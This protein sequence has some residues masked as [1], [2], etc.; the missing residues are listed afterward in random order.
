[1]T[2]RRNVL[3]SFLTAA[4]LAYSVPLSAQADDQAMEI[5]ITLT[6]MK[7]M[8]EAIGGKHVDVSVLVPPGTHPRSFE[9]TPMQ[10]AAL[11][12]S[13]LYI[14][15]GIPH[16]QNWLPQI[17]A[18]R[19]DMPML[20]FIESV[21]TRQRDDRDIEDPHI[22]LGPQQLRDMAE[23][24]RDTLS[25]LA[26]NHADEFAVNADAW[27]ARLDA[28]DADAKVRLAPYEGRAFLVFH[29]AFGYFADSYGLRQIAIEQRG[30]EPGPQRI[31]SAIDRARAENIGTVFMQV[32][33]AE[34]EAKTIAS[35]IGAKVVTSNPLAPDLIGN[36]A[37]IAVAIEAS[38]Q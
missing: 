26:P 25:D 29:P 14:V 30:M 24:L 10:M 33:F 23:G 22:W 15:M 31:A 37:E 13:A 2:T 9:P 32:G 6:P 18:A 8:V 35:E 12:S 21:E 20:S 1:M 7:A 5:T 36:L 4:A 3:A 19:P 16:E 38:F 34:D 11:N 27:I 28:A 17:Q